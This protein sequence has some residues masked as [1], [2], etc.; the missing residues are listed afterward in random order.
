MALFVFV[1]NRRDKIHE[2]IDNAGWL[3]WGWQQSNRM[4]Y[5]NITGNMPYSHLGKFYRELIAGFEDLSNNSITEA[6]LESAKKTRIK[7]YKNKLYD[8]NSLNVH[9]LYYHTRNGYSLDKIS[10]M[11]DDIKAVTVDDV[12]SAAKRIFDPDNFVMSMSGNLDS[13][14]T[15]LGQFNN[16]EF[17]ERGEEIRISP[18]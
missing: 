6:E 12:N 9:I 8:I 14:S 1:K 15:F 4:P 5:F 13:C 10:K 18:K 2:K 17:Y 7:D 11:V 3:N 16:V